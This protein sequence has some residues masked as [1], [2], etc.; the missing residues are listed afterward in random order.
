[1]HFYYT[2]IDDKLQKIVI[3]GR[4]FVI[5]TQKIK[6]V[7]C[8]ISITLNIWRLFEFCWRERF[9]IENRPF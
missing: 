5:I 8:N 1:M 9:Y 3:A 7:F 6:E 4:H 2:T